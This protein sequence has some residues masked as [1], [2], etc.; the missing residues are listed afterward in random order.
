M[1]QVSLDWSAIIAAASVAGPVLLYLA[2][3]D[4][5]LARIEGRLAWREAS[6]REGD[7]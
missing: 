7:S 6:A 2:Q 1:L 5:R 3:L 4:R